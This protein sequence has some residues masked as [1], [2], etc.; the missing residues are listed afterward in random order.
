MAQSAFGV[1]RNA[2]RSAASSRPDHL[3]GDAVRQTR[4][5]EAQCLGEHRS[6][7]HRPNERGESRPQHADEEH[8]H[9][10]VCQDESEHAQV[11]AEHEHDAEYQRPRGPRERQHAELQRALLDAQHVKRDE[12]EAG[13]EG[14]D[15]HQ[16]QRHAV[17]P[18]TEQH[19]REPGRRDQAGRQQG[20]ID[21]QQEEEERAR[22]GLPAV[23]VR[24]VVVQP[25]ERGVEAQARQDLDD[26]LHR[27]EQREDAV[28]ARGEKAGEEV[29]QDEA[30]Q[31]NGDI[32]HAVD[33][34]VEEERSEPDE[35]VTLEPATAE[36]P[37][38]LWRIARPRTPGVL[39]W[40]RSP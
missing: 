7:E 6:R 34:E 12:K 1:L 31:L 38:R 17:P 30:G 2:R 9:H 37:R 19:W 10:D 32:T 28:V 29:Q 24:A 23:P 14:V 5:P 26:D 35:H 11:E 20:G 22:Q 3:L 21:H 13:D 16:R 27:E 18:D 40:P 8:R 36:N 25:H 4:Q 15:Q 33:D 39:A